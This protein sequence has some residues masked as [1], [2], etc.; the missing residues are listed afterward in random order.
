MGDIFQGG[1]QLA[2]LGVGGILGVGVLVLGWL[3]LKAYSREIAR[4]DAAMK[5]WADA[6]EQFERALNLIEK[7]QSRRR[8]G[9]AG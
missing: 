8:S 5:G 1:S 6:T 4:G 9:D 7:M 2:S 3:H